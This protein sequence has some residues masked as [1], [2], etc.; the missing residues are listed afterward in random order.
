MQA[1]IF[2]ATIHKDLDSISNNFLWGDTKDRKRIQLVGKAKTFISLS[3]G[4]LGIME[5]GLMNKTYMAKLGW[6]L[7]QAPPI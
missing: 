2:P 1:T 3:C 7:A 5:Q 4:G 6:R